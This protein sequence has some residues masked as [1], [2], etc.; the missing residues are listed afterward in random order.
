MPLRLKEN[1]VNNVHGKVFCK[2]CAR[3]EY[4]KS[5]ADPK[6]HKCNGE[7]FIIYNDYHSYPIN[8]YNTI[9]CECECLKNESKI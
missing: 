6:C 2:W 7:G 4:L 8:H 3:K 5:K 9:E 1:I